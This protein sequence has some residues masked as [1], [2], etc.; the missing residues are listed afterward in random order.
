MEKIEGLN[1]G[2]LVS[3]A[4]RISIAKRKELALS[5]VSKL[6][7]RIEGLAQEEKKLTQQLKQ[8]NEKI[9]KAQETLDKIK[10]G[11]WSVLSN[12]EKEGGGEAKTQE[13]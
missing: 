5:L 13:Q 8:N 9:K 4:S 7:H 6:M 10:A 11:D 3:E 12:L 2:D 1:L